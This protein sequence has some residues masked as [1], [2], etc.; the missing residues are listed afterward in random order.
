MT[1]PAAVRVLLGGLFVAAG[2]L[3]FIVPGFYEAMIPPGYPVPR[4]L[5]L[6]SGVA[7]F[8]GGLGL[9]ARSARLRRWAGWGL[10]GLLI[11]VYPANVHMALTMDAPF[12]LL[13]ARL[14]LQGALV[15]WVLRSSGALHASAGRPQSDSTVTSPGHASRARSAG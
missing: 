8:A 7:E 12:G 5:V 1:R 10:V 6:W 11:A 4:A 15:A 13:W 3:H 2:V 14:A 9:L